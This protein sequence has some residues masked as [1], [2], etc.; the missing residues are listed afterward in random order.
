VEG[1]RVLAT[2][3]LG[4]VELAALRK[5]F[6]YC[7]VDEASQVMLPVCL[8]PLRYASRFILVGDHYQLPP[9]LRQP[10]HEVGGVTV[11]LFKRLCEAHPE[12]IISLT[13]QYRMNA[14][15]MALA[16][17]LIYDGRLQC[18]TEAVA[19]GTLQLSPGWRE[20]LAHQHAGRVQRMAGECWLEHAVDPQRAVVFVD[21]DGMG[22]R[23]TREG[24][25]LQNRGE[26][27][28]VFQVGEGEGVGGLG[29]VA[30]PPFASWYV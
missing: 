25:V 23:E 10:A 27:S 2:T 28:L 4:I 7:I 18:G 11:S 21:T 5:R 24:E 13:H 6:D 19:T 16:N 8:G 17:R 14:E 26:V 9:L 1:H 15:I 3:C 12:A 22:C 30:A 29:E 20:G